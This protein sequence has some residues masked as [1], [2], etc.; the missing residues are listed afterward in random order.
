MEGGADLIGESCLRRTHHT[1]RVLVKRLSV[2][3]RS[4]ERGRVGSE[5]ASERGI[6][7]DKGRR[8]ER[9]GNKR[10]CQGREGGKEERTQAGCQSFGGG[11]RGRDTGEENV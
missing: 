2:G 10:P 7:E 8:R 3:R 1:Q 9:S 5:Q 4:E 6:G 11:L